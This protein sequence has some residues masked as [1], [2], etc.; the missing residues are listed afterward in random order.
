MFYHK[1]SFLWLTFT[2]IIKIFLR[3]INT[4]FFHFSNKILI[5]TFQF[6]ILLIN[7]I[8]HQ[9]SSS[10]VWTAFN[11]L[12]F[13]ASVNLLDSF[14]I[15][16]CLSFLEFSAK[17]IDFCG[18]NAYRLLPDLPVSNRCFCWTYNRFF[19]HPVGVTKNNLKYYNRIMMQL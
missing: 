8:I 14:G 3:P 4:G 9:R 12:R 7:T 1:N 6:P 18:L 19:D 2:L 11:D 13:T 5:W 10:R 15:R 16:F 17:T